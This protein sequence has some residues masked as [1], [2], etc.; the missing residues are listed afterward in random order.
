MRV[1]LR[2]WF[3]CGLIAA[4]GVTGCGQGEHRTEIV[5]FAASSLAESLREIRTNF[6]ALHPESKL[7]FHLAGSQ[8]LRTQ[9]E[10]GATVDVYISADAQMVSDLVEMHLLKGETANFAK[11]RV[12]VLIAPSNPGGIESLTDLAEPG[13]R[14]VMGIA[15]VPIGAATRDLLDLLERS[16]RYGPQF[17][18]QLLD[19]VVSEEMNVRGVIAR[20][21]LGEADAAFAYESDSYTKAAQGMTSIT[22]PQNL[23]VE[24]QYAAGA[25]FEGKDG[26]PP[27]LIRFLN[28]EVSKRILR[29][30]GLIVT[31]L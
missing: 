9:I 10:L 26:F 29:A 25:L 5:V 24:V 12:Q 19:N 31:G 14:L 13:K 1:L 7:L 18:D 22:L 20:L 3:L 15:E 2:I 16:P 21:A 23:T 28:S 11:N 4:A 6:E 17:V 8:Q 30:H 27:M